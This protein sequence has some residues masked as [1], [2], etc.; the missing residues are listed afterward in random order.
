MGHVNT[1]PLGTIKC[2]AVIQQQFNS[3]HFLECIDSR[4][5][6]VVK[7]LAKGRYMASM[8]VMEQGQLKYAY[9][10]GDSIRAAYYDVLAKIEEQSR[11][12]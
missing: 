2:P 8:Y 1:T 7:K 3:S 5:K 9:A 4:L 12:L 10:I 11:C 6:M